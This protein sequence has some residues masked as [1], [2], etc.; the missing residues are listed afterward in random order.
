MASNLSFNLVTDFLQLLQ[1]R[2]DYDPGRLNV[3]CLQGVNPTP[4]GQLQANDNADDVYNDAI[5]LAWH[6]ETGA[7]QVQAYLGT[8]DPGLAYRDL[9]GGEAHLT[10]GQHF[11]VRGT[12]K[13]RPALRAKGELNRVWRDPDKSNMP[14]EGDYVSIGKFGVNIHPGGTT[15]TIGN[16]SAGCINICGSWTGEPW[17]VF[18]QLVDIHF[19]SSTDIGVTVWRGKDYLRF[20]EAG[21]IR[22]TLSFGILNPWVVELQKLLAAK[23]YYT[24]KNDGDWGKA[25]ELAVRNFQDA[26]KLKVDGVVGPLTWG[27]LLAAPIVT[28]PV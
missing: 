6:T 2:V 11:Y 7:R 20:A 21:A 24:G 17:K 1:V 10:F 16:W 27:R 19:R 23:G 3:L 15:K 28:E 13:G 5:V 18:M 9:P 8:V 4:D 22:P 26:Q 12:H 14:S 25:T